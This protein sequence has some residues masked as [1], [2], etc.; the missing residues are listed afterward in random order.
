ME[1]ADQEQ[2]LSHATALLSATQLPH[3]GPRW[4][5]DELLNPLQATDT[6]GLATKMKTRLARGAC[7]ETVFRR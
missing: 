6:T 2:D 4:S 7:D 1:V 5:I 3:W